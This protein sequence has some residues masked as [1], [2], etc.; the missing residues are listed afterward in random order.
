MP[1]AIHQSQSPVFPK[2]MRLLAHYTI[3]TGFQKSVRLKRRTRRDEWQGMSAGCYL[4]DN[5]QAKNAASRPTPP[6][7][8]D[9]LFRNQYNQ[10]DW[11]N[12]SNQES[13]HRGIPLLG[14]LIMRSL[15]AG[16]TLVIRS[17]PLCRR[18]AAEF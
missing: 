6:P 1:R 10:T 15:S 7:L 11:R 9:N 5:S 3:Y 8:L 4:D 13:R 14:K 2:L 17:D 12:S 18:T 16:T